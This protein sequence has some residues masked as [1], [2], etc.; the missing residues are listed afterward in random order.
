MM[1]II[2][3]AVGGKSLACYRGRT[4]SDGKEAIKERSLARE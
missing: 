4:G 1:K 2:N 3:V